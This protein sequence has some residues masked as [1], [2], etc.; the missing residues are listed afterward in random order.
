[1]ADNVT[2]E[3]IG[4]RIRRTE[5]VKDME[6][7]MKEER[8]QR[9]MVLPWKKVTLDQATVWMVWLTVVASVF[10]FFTVSAVMLAVR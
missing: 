3:S 10:L 8:V 5:V 1:M 7:L 6:K 9:Y 4:A 2:H